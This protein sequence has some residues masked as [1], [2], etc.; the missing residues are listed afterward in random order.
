M[1]NGKCSHRRDGE[2]TVPWAQ[3]LQLHFLILLQAAQE[4]YLRASRATVPMLRGTMLRSARPVPLPLSVP[5]HTLAPCSRREHWD[6]DLQLA[7]EAARQQ[8]CPCSEPET[9]SGARSALPNSLGTGGTAWGTSH[10]S[11]AWRPTPFGASLLCKTQRQKRGPK[12]HRGLCLLLWYAA[13]RSGGRASF[14][15]SHVLG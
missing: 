15:A 12:E 14:P 9:P 6:P 8:S 3:H 10:R 11:T 1:A 2:V 13:A 4:N 5:E 7:G